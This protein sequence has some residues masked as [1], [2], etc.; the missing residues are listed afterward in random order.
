M[1]MITIQQNQDCVAKNGRA[2]V[3]PKALQ[4]LDRWDS[5][6]RTCSSCTIWK[7]KTLAFGVSPW[8]DIK[9]MM[10][11]HKIQLHKIQLEGVDL[12][13]VCGKLCKQNAYAVQCGQLWPES[14]LGHIPSMMRQ[15]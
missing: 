2:E 13:D 3:N 4:P 12:N 8:A 5:I 14:R 10:L 1:P 11:L 7:G 15:M 9:V 6:W